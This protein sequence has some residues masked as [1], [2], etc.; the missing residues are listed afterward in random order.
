MITTMQMCAH[1][2][3][4]H[5]CRGEIKQILNKDL[6]ELGDFTYFLDLLQIF[7]NEIERL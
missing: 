7:H 2:C 6:L 3:A 4:C 5:M 1:G